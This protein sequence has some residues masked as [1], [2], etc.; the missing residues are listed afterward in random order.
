[1]HPAIM[2]QLAADHIQELRSSAKDG[3]RAHQAR[4]HPEPT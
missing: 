3:R 4:R 2:W 1:M